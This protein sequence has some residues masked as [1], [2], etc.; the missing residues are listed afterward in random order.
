M[1]KLWLSKHINLALHVVV[2]RPKLNVN[3]VISSEHVFT[4]KKSTFFFSLKIHE[5]LRATYRIFWHDNWLGY[6]ISSR[7]HIPKG[8]NTNA[9]VGNFIVDNTWN[10]PH[11]F[12]LSFPAIVRDISNVT[13]AANT[14]DELRWKLCSN[15][16]PTTR[17]FYNS[18]RHKSQE[19]YCGERI[20]RKS[21]QP[22]RSLTVWKALHNRLPTEE[23]LQ[24]KGYS[25]SSCCRLCYAAGEGLEHLFIHCNFVNSIW[26]RLEEVFQLN[27]DKTTDLKGP[28][29]SVFKKQMSKQV[30]DLWIASVISTIWIVWKLRNLAIFE[31]KAPSQVGHYYNLKL[32]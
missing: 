28:L 4:L 13:I 26:T 19:L 29:S 24:I 27:L 6:K 15:G 10:I 20:W 17:D 11:Q 5:C 31:G 21:I 18:C 8:I 12:R 1:S 16:R 32:C 2:G 22:R 14:K 25:L 9:K 23:L 7:V 3:V 30:Y